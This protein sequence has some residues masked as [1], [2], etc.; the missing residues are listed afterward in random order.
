MKQKECVWGGH[1]GLKERKWE[2]AKNLTHI[3]NI[4]SQYFQFSLMA[5]SQLKLIS[6]L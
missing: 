4:L 1:V 2:E 3:E 6:L 5:Y